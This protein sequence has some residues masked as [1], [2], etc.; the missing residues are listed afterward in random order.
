MRL[1]QVVD[2]HSKTPFVKLQ[3]RMI[4]L[5]S[6]A[7]LGMYVLGSPAAMVV[8]SRMGLAIANHLGRPVILYCT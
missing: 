3:N 5:L 4:V 8:V 6:R 1:W 2:E 7:R